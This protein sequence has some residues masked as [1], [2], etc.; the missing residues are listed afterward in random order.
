MKRVYI[1]TALTSLAMLLVFSLI[2]SFWDPVT[3]WRTLK[4]GFIYENDESTP[5]TNNFARAQVY[6]EEQYHD[7]IQV[8]S[9]SN[10]LEEETEAPLRELVDEGCNI[11]FTNSYSHQ[12]RD[13]AKE[14]PD[15]QFCQV[16]YYDS[17]EEE[18]PENYHTFKGEVYQGRYVSGIVAGMKLAE[19]MDNR[20]IYSDDAL[21]GYVAAFP[22]TEVISGYT[23]FLL[24]VRSIVPT[25]TMRVLYTNTW[26]SYVLEKNAAKRLIDEGCVIISQHTD[27]IGPAVACEESF[28][29]SHKVYHVGYNQSMIDV[30][31][32]TS[33]VSTR[34][35]WT[36]YIVGAI[37]AVMNEKTIEKEVEGRVHGI[38]KNDMS[39]GFDLE[40]VQILELN[41]HITAFGTEEK[42]RETVNAL[43]RKTI[44]VFEGNYIGINP[45]D[46]SD[47]IDLR[48]GYEENKDCSSPTFHYILKD[49]ITTDVIN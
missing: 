49:V 18:L 4:V 45:D 34:I 9:R 8:V 29:K 12:F 27:T 42:V 44:R 26:S 33:L 17:H 43:N 40:W 41:N 32:T 46:E 1:A 15:I 11:I 23:A 38:S 10:V 19:M 31:P 37:E 6:L 20:V 24:G 25:A 48:H 21:V 36:P 28:I 39:A 47:I 7:K 14:F 35:N 13:V 3:K 30:A 5:Y 22:T 2:Y 16:S